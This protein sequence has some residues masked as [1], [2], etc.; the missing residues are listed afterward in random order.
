MGMAGERGS[1]CAGLRADLVL[2]DADGKVL[3]TWIGGKSEVAR[4]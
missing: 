4:H 1:I 2:I 3:E